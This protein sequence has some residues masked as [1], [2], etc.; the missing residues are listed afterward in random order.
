VAVR[1]QNDMNSLPRAIRQCRNRRTAC[2]E[3]SGERELSATGARGEWPGSTYCVV[4]MT[5]TFESLAEARELASPQMAEHMARSRELHAAGVLVMAGA[6][7]DRPD[8]PV[9][10]MGVLISREAVLAFMILATLLAA[11]GVVTDSQVTIVGALVVGPEFGP[12]AAL[13]VALLRRRVDMARRAATALLVGFPIA[14]L[15][16]GLLSSLARVTGL[17]NPHDIAGGRRET[18]F[19]RSAARSLPASSEGQAE[20]AGV[21]RPTASASGS[22]AASLVAVCRWQL[23][24]GPAR[25]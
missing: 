12:L 21:G 14:L 19:I 15:A 13:A 10:T 23:V 4:F 7:L 5:T 18:E 11:I 3:Q 25:A 9:Q 6:L 1:A 17:V 16:T 24:S 8:Q 22:A 20:E 2:G